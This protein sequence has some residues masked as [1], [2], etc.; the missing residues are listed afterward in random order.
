MEPTIGAEDGVYGEIQ[1]A[2][3]YVE[4]LRLIGFAR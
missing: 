4:V 3:D 1:V 2:P